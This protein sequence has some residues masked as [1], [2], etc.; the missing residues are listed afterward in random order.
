MNIGI[1]VLDF[2]GVVGDGTNDDYAGIQAALDSGAGTVYL[3]KPKNCYLI[4]QTLRVHSEQ[5]VVADRYARIKLADQANCLMLANADQTS[6]DHGIGIIGG[7][8]D[9]NNA[10]QSREDI[11]A[12]T[13]DPTRYI[14]IAMQFLNVR[15]LHMS[16]LTFRDPESF[17]AQLGNVD[18]FTVEDI[19]FDYNLLRPNMD[20]IHCNGPCSNGRIC[21]LK[22]TT[23]DDLVALNAD[24]GAAG[25][26]TRGPIHDILIDGI[27][28]DNG[29]TAVRLLSAGSPVSRVKIANVYGT[30]RYNVLS[31]THHD[32]HPGAPSMFEDISID[33]V[34]ASKVWV[35]EP[36]TDKPDTVVAPIR[37]ASG[38]LVKNVH[39]SNYHRTETR[40]PADDICVEPGAKVEY[41]AVS[42]SS[43]RNLTGKPVKLIS[44][45]GAID[46]LEMSQ[47]WEA[48]DGSDASEGK[49]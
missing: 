22:G 47:V 4:S 42:N 31:F 37:I 39:I 25:E 45:E 1:N 28:S 7:V 18:R 24:D 27:Y 34:F 38:V 11:H 49:A 20:G 19:A 29:Y 35:E 41:M 17:A 21:N 32:V 44:N 2:A 40:V 48:P 12:N 43:M 26:P 3:P 33:G 9:G 30:Y 16:G 15:D 46:R 6:G 10:N 8:W 23:N 13:Y 14:G 5:T 36:S